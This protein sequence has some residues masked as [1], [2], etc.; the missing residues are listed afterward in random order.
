MWSAWRTTIPCV[1]ALTALV[2]L[3]VQASEQ[4]SGGPYRVDSA[5]ITSGGTLSAGG[6]KL[7]G[8]IGQPLVGAIA[9]AGYQLNGGFVGAD[10]LV[11]RGGFES[12]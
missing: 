11:F 9:A 8:S 2:A 7:R 10:D 1:F 12:Q 4:P 6:W 3:A 5:V